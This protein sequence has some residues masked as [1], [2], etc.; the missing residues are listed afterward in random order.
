M[1][2]DGT[3]ITWVVLKTEFLEKYFPANVC[4]KKNIEFL[5]LKQG[6]MIVAKHTAKFEELV[7]FCPHYNG[8]VVVGLKCI[9][10]ESGLLPEIKQFIG[11]Q[12]ILR[13][14][15]LVNK[16]MIYDEDNMARSSH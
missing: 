1:E 15:V 11:Y 16:C 14:A 2:V 8:A 5:E 4:S 10:F 12:E 13:F 7:G 3:D 9:K 6:N